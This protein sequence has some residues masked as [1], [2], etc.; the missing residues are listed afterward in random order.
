MAILTKILEVLRMPKIESK[1]TKEIDA[2]KFEEILFTKISL[3]NDCPE[4]GSKYQSKIESSCS[5]C[6]IPRQYIKESIY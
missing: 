5:Y 6:G 3:Y 4:C 2:K 1:G